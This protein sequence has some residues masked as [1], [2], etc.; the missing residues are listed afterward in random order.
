MFTATEKAARRS[1]DAN[2]NRSIAGN[3]LNES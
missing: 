3:A 1:C 2:S